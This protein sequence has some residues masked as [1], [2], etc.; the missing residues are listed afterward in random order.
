MDIFHKLREFVTKPKGS[1]HEVSEVCSHFSSQPHHRALDPQYLSQFHEAIKKRPSLGN[2]L[3]NT[4]KDTNDTPLLLAAAETCIVR[5]GYDQ[6]IALLENARCLYPQDLRITDTI[7]RAKL[8]KLDGKTDNIGYELKDYFCF[9]PFVYLSLTRGGGCFCC[10]SSWLPTTIGNVYEDDVN[11][12]WNSPVIEDI[13][14]S[15]LDGSFSFCD[16]MSCYMIMLRLLPHRNTLSDYINDKVG[17]LSPNIKEKIRS[18]ALE[19]PTMGTV[20]P[21]KPFFLNLANDA[22]CN[23]ACPSCRND[24]IILDTTELR[25]IDEATDNVVIP[26]LKTAAVVELSG[27]GDPFASRSCMRILGAIDNNDFPDLK[28]VL[29]TNGNLLNSEMW[30]RFKNLARYVASINISIDAATQQTYSLL[31]RGGDFYTVIENAKFAGQLFRHG[32]IENLKLC[33][34]VQKENFNEMKEFI[35]LAREIGASQVHFQNLANFTFTTEQ[36]IEKAVHLP[37]HPQYGQ[38]QELIKD[39]IFNDSTVI[40]EVRV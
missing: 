3:L 9:F 2:I 15:I 4:A 11:N 29:M 20:M 28:L 32:K 14:T 38:L 35:Y 19:I 23:L 30:Q 36:Y 21:F 22:S 39:P 1:N 8:Y 25:E 13:R 34:V 27:A 37:P 12:V 17:S 40:L 16:K 5:G 18:I 10:C 6:A 26:L 31:R 24:K 33:Y 7:F